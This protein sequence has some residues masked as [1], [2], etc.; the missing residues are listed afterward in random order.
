MLVHELLLLSQLTT[1]SIYSEN[2]FLKTLNGEKMNGEKCVFVNVSVAINSF[3]L[4]H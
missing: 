1:T 2:S 4:D 3:F